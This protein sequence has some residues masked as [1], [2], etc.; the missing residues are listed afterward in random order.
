[1]RSNE[2]DVRKFAFKLSKYEL[3]QKM[4]RSKTTQILSDDELIVRAKQGDKAARDEL[5]SVYLPHVWRTVYLTNG[6]G[7]DTDDFVQIAMIK[8]LEK[9]PSYRGPGKFKN[10]LEMIAV[11]TVRQHY[12]W[13][14]IRQKKLPYD[15]VEELVQKE[16]AI[17]E[18]LDRKKCFERLARHLGKIRKE[19]R[20]AL[21]LS[22][23]QGR[24]AKEIAELMGCNE[25]A[26][27]KRTRRGYKE[28][29]ERLDRDPAFRQMKKELKQ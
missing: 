12:R 1:M 13:F 22:V 7:P 29:I 14:R 26:A 9:L 6:G 10:W 25:E 2:K 15:P 8:A 28:L 20:I 5:V 23:L 16:N 27:W 4:P 24:T 11:N 18:E 19:R 17:E 21:V 3:E